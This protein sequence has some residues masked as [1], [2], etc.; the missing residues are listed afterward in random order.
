MVERWDIIT[1]GNPSRNRYWGE[2]DEKGLRAAICTC[3][4]VRGEEFCLLVDPSLEDANR[5]AVELDRR[6]GVKV[7]DVNAVFV[8]HEHGDHHYGLRH[9]PEASWLAAPEVAAK[10]DESG[11]YA[12]KV[13]GATGRLFDAVEVIPTPGHTREHHSLLFECDGLR[14]VIAGDA[15][16][17]REFWR[18]RQGYFNSVDFEEAARTIERLKERADI[19]V[20]GHDNYFRVSTEG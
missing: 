12:K 14:V 11:A 19:V 1:I 13:E 18:H 10:I 17:T 9:F 2:S 20:P 5:M 6:T 3:T 4:L 7:R 8:T 16:M 15:V